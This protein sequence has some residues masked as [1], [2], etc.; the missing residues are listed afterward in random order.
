MCP[1]GPP[2][3]DHEDAF[4][5]LVRLA[6]ARHRVTDRARRFV[7]VDPA[8]CRA[9]D[10]REDDL[11]GRELG[12]VLHKEDRDHAARLRDAFIAGTTDEILGEWCLLRRDGMA[13]TVLYGTARL[14]SRSAPTSP[15]FNLPY[16]TSSSCSNGRALT[17]R[18]QATAPPYE[19]RRERVEL[20]AECLQSMNGGLSRSLLKKGGA[21]LPTLSR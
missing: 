6:A 4:R 15:S 14:R 11:L 7:L 3:L 2:W 10:C 18:L 9:F 8:Y 20:A 21:A 12:L 13:R 1:S 19:P 17:G 5:A 16:P